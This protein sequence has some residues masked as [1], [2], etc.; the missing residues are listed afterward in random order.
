M[1]ASSKV[2]PEIV[3]KIPELK[4]KLEKEESA[5]TESTEEHLGIEDK[6]PDNQKEL[7]EASKVLLTKLTQLT[8]GQKGLNKIPKLLEQLFAGFGMYF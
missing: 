7:L 1:T 3:T 4:Y 5:Y 2:D 6:I 8:V